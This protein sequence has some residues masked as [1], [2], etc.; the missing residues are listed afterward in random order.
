MH[1]NCAAAKLSE[2]VQRWQLAGRG[3]G[4]PSGR[5]PVYRN[6]N[7][8]DAMILWYANHRIHCRSIRLT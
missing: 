3:M 1:T 4:M 2:H 7:T 6:T 5:D 8:H